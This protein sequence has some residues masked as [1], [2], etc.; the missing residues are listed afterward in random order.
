MIFH[1]KVHETGLLSTDEFIIIE[2]HTKIC[3]MV[4]IDFGWTLSDLYSKISQNRGQFGHIEDI[5]RHVM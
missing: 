2:E 3:M 1:I 4:F 5:Y